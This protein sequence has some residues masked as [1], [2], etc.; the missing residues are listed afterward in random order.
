MTT[1]KPDKPAPLVDRGLEYVHQVILAAA[2]RNKRMGNQAPRAKRK[3]TKN[4]KLER[5][6]QNALNA[7]IRQL[8]RD[9]HRWAGRKPWTERQRLA[10]L[11]LRILAQ[12]GRTGAG[13]T[14]PCEPRE[15]DP[16]YKDRADA[17]D[18]RWRR[19]PEA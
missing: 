16:P 6:G 4:E 17:A 15:G 12:G 11:D 8:S 19:L 13:I 7:R 3:L 14:R 2:E 18:R 1:D 5:L 10:A 9:M